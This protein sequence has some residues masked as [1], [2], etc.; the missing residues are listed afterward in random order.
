MERGL[1]STPIYFDNWFPGAQIDEYVASKSGNPVF[2]VGDIT[3]IHQ[4][5]WINQKKGGIPFGDSALYIS[6]SNYPIDPILI[7]GKRFS[8]IEC[9]DSVPEMRNGQLTRFFH[10]YLMRNRK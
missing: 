7:Y 5:H 2:G 9:I 1:Q 6:V 8:T 10:L 4:Y 3:R